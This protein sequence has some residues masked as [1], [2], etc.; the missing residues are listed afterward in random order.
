MCERDIGRNV[1]VWVGVCV[2]VYFHESIGTYV[3][4][5]MCVQYNIIEKKRDWEEK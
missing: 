5:C 4:V 1:H 2:H 3:H